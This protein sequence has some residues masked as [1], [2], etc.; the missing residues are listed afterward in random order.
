MRPDMVGEEMPVSRILGLACAN[1]HDDCARRFPPAR[2]ASS[3]PH[4]FIVPTF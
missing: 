3:I 2:A 4:P 1:S